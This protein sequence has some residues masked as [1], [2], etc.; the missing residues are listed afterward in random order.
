M[1][2]RTIPN[3]TAWISQVFGAQSANNGG[4]VRRSVADVKQFGGGLKRLKAEVRQR[5]YHL[6][7]TGD[8]Y[9]ILCHKGDVR[10]I[11]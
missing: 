6:I 7:R 1:A 3:S 4:V 5:G 8:Q 10:V 11:C 2:R 9:V